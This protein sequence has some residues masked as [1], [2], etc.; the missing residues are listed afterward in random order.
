VFHLGDVF[1]GEFATHLDELV[2]WHVVLADLERLFNSNLCRQPVA[3]PALWKVNVESFHPLV[4]GYEIDVA[5][6]QRVPDV[7]I[8]TGVWWWCVDTEGLARCV[9]GVEVVNVVLSPVLPPISLLDRRVVALAESIVD[10]RTWL[11]LGG[12]FGPFAI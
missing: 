8:A 12:I 3:V 10:A 1:A 5:P 2:R 9:M 4:A 11:V 6:V 7:K